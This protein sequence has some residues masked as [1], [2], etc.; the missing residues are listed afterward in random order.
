MGCIL[1]SKWLAK[2]GKKKKLASSTKTAE[3]KDQ[4][5]VVVKNNKP[6]R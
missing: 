5:E 1:F 3:R 6:K 2:N 4:Y